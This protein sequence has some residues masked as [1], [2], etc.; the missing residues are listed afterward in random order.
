MWSSIFP[1]AIGFLAL[2]AGYTHAYLSGKSSCEAE[3]SKSTLLAM[4]KVRETDQRLQ[5]AVSE[6][7]QSY[8]KIKEVENENAALRRAVDSGNKRLLIAAKCPTN[9]SSASESSGMGDEE[10]PELD[11]EARQDY[12][13]LRQGIEEQREQLMAC[14]QILDKEREIVR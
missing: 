12:F 13:D 5:E 3:Y 10:T 4:E 14:Q 11:P 1:Y 8:T 7:D 2:L 9:L 6:I